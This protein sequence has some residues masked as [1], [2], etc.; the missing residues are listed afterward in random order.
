MDFLAEPRYQK[1]REREFSV[2]PEVL[3]RIQVVTMERVGILIKVYP[4]N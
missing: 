3:V 1:S 4:A 2:V